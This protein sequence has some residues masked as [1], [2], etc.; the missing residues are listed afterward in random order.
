MHSSVRTLLLIDQCKML[1][2]TRSFQRFAEE[3]NR[4]HFI[5][6]NHSIRKVLKL[7]E[8][9]I[10]KITPANSLRNNLKISPLNHLECISR[11]MKIPPRS[12][13]QFPLLDSFHRW[14]G[15]PNR[16]DEKFQIP[17]AY[18]DLQKNIFAL[19]LTEPIRRES[20]CRAFS[21]RGS[22]I[23][24]G[25]ASS[26]SETY[27]LVPFLGKVPGS[28]MK[29]YAHNNCKY[30]ESFDWKKYS[31]GNGLWNKYIPSDIFENEKLLTEKSQIEPRQDIAQ[32]VRA[33]HTKSILETFQELKNSQDKS[34][35][36]KTGVHLCFDKG[37]KPMSFD[38]EIKFHIP[39]LVNQQ[40]AQEMQTHFK[41]DATLELNSQTKPFILSLSKAAYFF[42]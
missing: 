34:I 19:R 35:F 23:P 31:K 17:G 27:Q 2:N 29:S 40:E 36:S 30:L 13:P 33:W 1:K 26:G 38:G 32:L 41:G 5:S 4:D 37:L 28:G 42:D 6:Q 39:N 7:L 10:S 16:L 3:W 21:P 14:S 15:K 20:A 9:L 12:I 22:L 25:L 11:N 8:S 24:L 18:P